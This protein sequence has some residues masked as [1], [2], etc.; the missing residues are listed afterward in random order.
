MHNKWLF[1]TSGLSVRPINWMEVFEDLKISVSDLC[2]FYVTTAQQPVMGC[3]CVMKTYR[4]KGDVLNKLGV[5]GFSTARSL[6]PR[7]TREDALFRYMGG[8][9]ALVFE[10]GFQ[11]E[12]RMYPRRIH[13]AAAVPS[14]MEEVSTSDMERM[15]QGNY[16]DKSVTC[17]K[18]DKQ[19]H[20]H[21]IVVSLPCTAQA[22]PVKRQYVRKSKG[23]AEKVVAASLASVVVPAPRSDSY[24]LTGEMNASSSSSCSSDGE[25]NAPASLTDEQKF[26]MSQIADMDAGDQPLSAGGGDDDDDNGDEG[27]ALQGTRKRLK[28]YVKL[29]RFLKLLFMIC[30]T[31]LIVSRC[32]L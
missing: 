27:D 11:E 25:G 6:S 24:S 12:S 14:D 22:T 9:G 28:S 8:M 2:H 16:H 29:Y 32:F 31:F 4:S 20:V 15:I 7:F 17:K 13:A 3:F 18:R 21:G 10:T 19:H 5:F 30:T 23:S 26:V 1:A